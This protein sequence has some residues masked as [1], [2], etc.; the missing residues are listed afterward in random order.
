MKCRIG[1]NCLDRS[2]PVASEPDYKDV[3][4]QLAPFSTVLTIPKGAHSSIQVPIVN[5]SNYQ[6]GQSRPYLLFG[7]FLNTLTQI[8]LYFDPD[9]P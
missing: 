8:Y 5:K 3:H 2:I 6:M 4:E 7:P 9:I 1:D